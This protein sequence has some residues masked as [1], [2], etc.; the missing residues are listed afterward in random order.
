M[1]MW[2]VLYSITFVLTFFC[3]WKRALVHD[4][5][6]RAHVA[7][8]GGSQSSSVLWMWTLHHWLSSKVCTRLELISLK[9]TARLLHKAAAMLKRVSP[10][11]AQ[12]IVCC[13]PALCHARATWLFTADLHDVGWD[14]K[15]YYAF[16]RK[17]GT[18]NIKAIIWKW[19]VIGI[20]ENGL[21]FCVML[22]LST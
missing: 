20:G 12:S 8:I 15:V 16:E 10:A 7:R 3:T 4:T 18:V 21:H 1:Y 19:C 22:F 6:L 11:R 2:L 17:H 14:H 9:E 5:A 13:H